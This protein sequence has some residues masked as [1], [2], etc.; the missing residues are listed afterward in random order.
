VSPA[1]VRIFAEANALAGLS[2]CARALTVHPD[3]ALHAAFCRVLDASLVVL[4]QRGD[5]VP[6]ADVFRNPIV[7]SATPAAGRRDALS[8][9]L[10]YLVA[11]CP[12]G[13][14]AGPRPITTASVTSSAV[15]SLERDDTGDGENSPALVREA[16]ADPA[17]EGGPMQ[18]QETAAA[19]KTF[20]V[21]TDGADATP[22]KSDA[23]RARAPGL[24]TSL[25]AYLP[26]RSSDLIAAPHVPQQ[27]ASSSSAMTTHAGHG[28]QYIFHLLG[29]HDDEGT[30]IER[31]PTAEAVEAR[32][33]IQRHFVA[34]HAAP[35][36][37]VC[38]NSGAMPE[39][40]AN[41]FEYLLRLTPADNRD[42]LLQTM[43]A[44]RSPLMKLLMAHN[45]GRN[46]A[47][48]CANLRLLKAMLIALL[49][50]PRSDVPALA[51]R[52]TF[53][54][55]IWHV[56]AER[57]RADRRRNSMPHCVFN[58]VL[59]VLAVQNY[60]C[61]SADAL[62]PIRK[63]VA[64]KYR[65]ML[66]PKF[67]EALEAAELA[68]LAQTMHVQ[69]YTSPVP[70]MSP[71]RAVS[72]ALSDTSSARRRSRVADEEFPD[73][74][75]HSALTKRT[76]ELALRNAAGHSPTSGDAADTSGSEQCPASPIPLA[77]SPEAA[78]STNG[79]AAAD[80]VHPE[81]APP[82]TEAPTNK[83]R[84]PVAPLVARKPGRARMPLKPKAQIIS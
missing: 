27:D 56:L 2:A 28:A 36:L 6:M 22:T 83:P 4:N 9:F 25:A 17:A 26:G 41:V 63:Y 43:L 48:L 50:L 54:N 8:P 79:A 10:S 31:S 72:P 74:S 61:C 69:N 51:N 67:L 14:V 65:D 52:M 82:V 16:S 78:A 57:L 58:A 81:P 75:R 38:S 53:Q 15:S 68:E 24:F 71:S 19:G 44:S 60:D 47:E 11:T 20:A 1:V 62:H 77:T 73:E 3:A 80:R 33:A 59:D 12:T 32:A 7:A 30:T 37:T 23:R 39:G 70:F 21:P 66:P 34:H 45:G 46:K 42:R 29:L 40:V 18:R 49:G 76:R 64:I 13:A 5:E 35:L 84:R 55:D